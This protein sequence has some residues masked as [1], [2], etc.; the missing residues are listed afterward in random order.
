MGRNADKG[1]GMAVAK[2][3]LRLGDFVRVPIERLGADNEHL[4]GTAAGGLVG[5]GLRCGRAEDD[6]FH[7]GKT[8][9]ALDHG[10]FL[11]VRLFGG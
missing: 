3:L 1:A 11:P 7:A 4:L 6:V 5:N 2:R 8:V 10:R 9:H